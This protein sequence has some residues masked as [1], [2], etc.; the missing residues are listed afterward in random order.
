[1][2]IIFVVGKRREFSRSLEKHSPRFLK[3]KPAYEFL[4]SFLRTCALYEHFII[5]S[6]YMTKAS[7]RCSVFLVNTIE[8][9]LYAMWEAK[10]SCM[11]KDGAC[12]KH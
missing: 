6:Y 7:G 1:M 4:S 8:L 10:R 9:Y 12:Q 2:N 5:N 11:V 3:E